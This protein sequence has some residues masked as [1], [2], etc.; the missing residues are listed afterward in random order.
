MSFHEDQKEIDKFTPVTYGTKLVGKEII[1]DNLNII[2]IGFKVLLMKRTPE[3]PGKLMLGFFFEPKETLTKEA[4]DK[5]MKEI[6]Q[7]KFMPKDWRDF[8]A[9]KVTKWKNVLGLIK[10]LSKG[11]IEYWQETDVYKE[12]PESLQ[13]AKKVIMESIAEGLDDKGEKKNEQ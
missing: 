5:A 1:E 12:N 7:G 2:N 10:I 3:Y 4:Y 13:E 6:R 8:I 9:L 11:A